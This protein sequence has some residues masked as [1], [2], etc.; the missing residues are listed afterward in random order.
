[1]LLKAY[2]LYDN[3]SFQYHAPFFTHTHGSAVRM[4]QDLVN[5]I[6]TNIGRHPGDYV[7][8]CCGH[9]DDEKGAMHPLSALEHIIDA[10]VLVMVKPTGDLF[11]DAPIQSLSA[12]AETALRDQLKKKKEVK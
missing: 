5:D 6:N 2:T 7:L 9:Y 8:Y 1:M 4:L 3:K 11:R 10:K 12:E